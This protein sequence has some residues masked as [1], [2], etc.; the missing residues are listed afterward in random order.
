MVGS[1]VSA[2][3]CQ[4][5]TTYVKI[6]KKNEGYSS[7]ESFSI[8]NSAG[9]LIQSITLTDDSTQ[10]F[11]HC[12]ADTP[13]SQYVLKMMDSYGDVCSLFLPL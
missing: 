2:L 5:G 3:D 4:E 13:N 1:L 10:T 7:E 11:E 6:I 8:S 12:I 9:V